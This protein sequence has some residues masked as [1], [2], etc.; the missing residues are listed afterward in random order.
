MAEIFILGLLLLC[1]PLFPLIL[2]ATIVLFIPIGFI[3]L[4][5]RGQ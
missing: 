4:L 1:A 3:V 2:V 5:L